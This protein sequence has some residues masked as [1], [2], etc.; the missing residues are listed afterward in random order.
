MELSDAAAVGKV[1]PGLSFH[2]LRYTQ[3]TKLAEAG[4]DAPTIAAVLG[5]A[6]TKIAEHYPRTPVNI[7][8]TRGSV[9]SRNVIGT[10]TGKPSGEPTTKYFKL[11]VGRYFFHETRHLVLDLG[12]R[13]QADIEIENDLVKSGVLDLLQGI[14]DLRRRA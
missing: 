14:G 7:L 11:K 6:T 1:Q 4:C 9:R 12:V 8:W 5:Q 2:G 10:K 13:L 3:G